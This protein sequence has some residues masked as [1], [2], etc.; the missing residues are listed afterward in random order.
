MPRILPITPLVGLL[1]GL[2]L[3]S[4]AAPTAAAPAGSAREARAG[5]QYAQAHC[6]QCHA[7]GAKDRSPQA[8]APPF[9]RL[10]EFYDVDGL[11]ESLAE[12]IDVGN[13]VMPEHVLAP[14]EIDN[15]IAF[16][17][18]FPSSDSSLVAA[19]HSL[20]QRH[21]AGCHAVDGGKSPLSD[22][23]PFSRLPQR[24]PLGRFTEAYG[25]GM[26]EGHPRMPRIELGPDELSELAA[27][28]NT[29][30]QDRPTAERKG[31]P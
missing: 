1:L 31:R 11:A 20:A 23:P 30:G 16:L 6:G 26:F 3:A 12:G 9:R 29:L 19:G 7:L 2:C 4:G 8:K 18:S 22:A 27:Y 21:C 25:D 24:F 5:K 13:P 15:L 10:H 17:K 28:L 14:R